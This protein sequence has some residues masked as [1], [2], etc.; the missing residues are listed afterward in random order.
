[1]TNPVPKQTYL[2][3]LQA[4]VSHN[5]Q[6]V[7]TL[8]V[9]LGREERSWQ[10]APDQWSVDQCFEHLILSFNHW[11]PDVEEALATPEPVDADGLF[12]SSWWGR[13]LMGRL[14]AP[15]KNYRT[16]NKFVPED[17]YYPDVLTRFRQQLDHLSA[18][19]ERAVA[20]DL[21]TKFWW[22]K[23]ILIRFN[24]G[25]HLYAFVSH[26]ELHI[27]QARRALEA[28][29]QQTEVVVA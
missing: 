25:E 7:Q 5:R 15:Q 6:V 19:L 9:P 8:F 16:K 21:Q 14:W 29:A 20:A 3:D 17:T 10:P 18:L 4:R 27:G 23:E 2:A 12:R 11:L 26:D 28:H 22:H 1:M 13:R 24:L